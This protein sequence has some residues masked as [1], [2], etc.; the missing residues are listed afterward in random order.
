MVKNECRKKPSGAF[1]RADS[2]QASKDVQSSLAIGSVIVD[3]LLSRIHRS[4]VLQ[5]Q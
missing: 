1:E 2:G 5:K 3:N 4:T